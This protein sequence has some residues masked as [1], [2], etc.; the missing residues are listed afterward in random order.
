[1]SREVKTETVTVAHFASFQMDVRK[2]FDTRWLID[3]KGCPA[4][5]IYT[6]VEIKPP[7]MPVVKA[8]KHFKGPERVEGT[9]DESWNLKY[10]YQVEKKS[11]SKKTAAGKK[12]KKVPESASTDTDKVIPCT[13][14]HPHAGPHKPP[15]PEAETF[16]LTKCRQ[17]IPTEEMLPAKRKCPKC[18]K[19]TLV[20]NGGSWTVAEYSHMTMECNYR[21]K[22]YIVPTDIDYDFMDLPWG[23]RIEAMEKAVSEEKT[24]LD[25]FGPSGFIPEIWGMWYGRRD[26]F[27]ADLSRDLEKVAEIYSG[28]EKEHG[29]VKEK[30]P[31]GHYYTLKV[32]NVDH[33]GNTGAKYLVDFEIRNGLKEHGFGGVG[34]GIRDIKKLDETVVQILQDA[35]NI[36]KDHKELKP[37]Y[38]ELDFGIS[39]KSEVPDEKIRAAQVKAVNDIFW[40]ETHPEEK[41]ESGKQ[42]PAPKIYRFTVEL[43]DKEAE[44]YRKGHRIFFNFT[45]PGGKIWP[46]FGSFKD[47]GSLLESVAKLREDIEKL[48]V[49]ISRENISLGIRKNTGVDKEQLIAAL[50]EGI[51]PEVENKSEWQRKNTV[52]MVP[53]KRKRKKRAIYKDPNLVQTDLEKLFPLNQSDIFDFFEVETAQNTPNAHNTRNILILSCSQHKSK[54]AQE[55]PIDLYQGQSYKIVRKFLEENQG[56]NL[57]VYTLSAKYGLINA[58]EANEEE[59]WEPY[60]LKL[61]KE[62][63]EGWKDILD[64]ALDK[65]YFT[66]SN[67]FFYGSSLY[68]NTLPFEIPH[69]EGKIG[70]MLHQLKEWLNTL[71]LEV[72]A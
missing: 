70:E 61:N 62:T 49:P 53:M 63:S 56:I 7:T 20:K 43:L 24:F 31:K 32:E 48:P 30:K 16:F 11:R 44:A 10:E 66:N 59:P 33:P 14:E 71:K 22:I 38:E 65:D 68:Y 37:V 64:R 60:D 8:C 40:K 12:P 1:M 18:G 25:P 39:N 47:P 23:K 46:N 3:M 55:K 17:K 54:T 67:S 28:R 57:E 27:T 26:D 9:K 19:K 29:H 15:K 4:C 72:A 5:G 69:S 51:V 52:V 21:E 45:T 58:I 6:K 34:V 36:I 41:K 50:L 42:K 35:N 2:G 13:L